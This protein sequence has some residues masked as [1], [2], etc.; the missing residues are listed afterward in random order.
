MSSRI[1]DIFCPIGKGTRGLIVAPPRTGKTT[2]LKDIAYG[3]TAN[4]PECH[5]MILLVDE[6]PEEVTDFR[7]D[8]P[9]AEIFA[10]SNDENI[11]THIR[12]ADL[13]LERAKH[14]VEVGRDVVLLMD[15]I[16]RL[17]RAHNSAKADRK[18][19]V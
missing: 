7:M 17:S 14:L 13:A 1:M 5:L 4:H 18:S 11:D 3:V 6:R 19:V 8:L 15:S 9:Q 12:V 2:L 10:S 16:T